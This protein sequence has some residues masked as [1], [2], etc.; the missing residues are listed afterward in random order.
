MPRRL[1]ALS[2]L[3]LAISSIA[4][5]QTLDSRD[6][7]GGVGLL[8]TPSARMAEEGEFAVTASRTSPYTR[9][10]FSLQPFPW[11]EGNFRY[12]NVT[13]VP[14][15]P[16]WLSGDQH[17]KD[18]SVDVKVRLWQ[19][20]RYLPEV[21][22]GVRDL[23]GTGLFASEYLV[24]S[25]RFGSVDASLGF[26]TG[27]M[28]S[29]GDFANPLGA[30]KERFKTRP[31]TSSGT[32]ADTGQVSWK[33]MFRGRVGVFGG[34]NWQTPW[35]RLALKL[36]YDGNDYSQEGRGLQIEQDSPI[37]L[38]AVFRLGESA[39][40]TVG[41][42]RGNEAVV[43]LTL[44]S[45]FAK[46][47]PAPKPLDPPPVALK[48]RATRA[49]DAAD[50]ADGIPYRDAAA[51]ASARREQ[52]VQ[53]HTAVD[54][55]DVSAQ[56]Y[57]NAGVDVERIGVRGNEL[58][59]AGVQGQY[60][61]PAQSLGRMAR[62][63][64][65][66]ASDDIEWFTLANRRTGL[67]VAETSIHRD[68]FA[69][70]VDGRIGL[71]ELMR[72]VELNP[73]SQQKR[74]PLHEVPVKPFSQSTGFGYSQIIGG[75]DGFILYQVSANYNANWWFNKNLWLA[76][77]ASY[78]L[79]NNYDKFRYDAP[80]NLPRVR[81][82]MR[83]FVTTSDFT[84]PNLQLTGTY[85]FSRD[86]YGMAYAGL[87]EYMYGGAGGELLYR[88][89]G[90]RWALGVDANW[91]KQRSYR[92]NASFRDY[93]V[94]TGHAT[95]YYTFGE[96]QRVA[97]A[98]SAGRYLAGDWGA[99]LSLTRV[100]DNGATMGAY[101]TKTDVSSEEFGEGSFDKGIYFSIP[102]DFLLPRSTQSRGNIMWQPL[103]RDGGARLIR[104]YNLHTLTGDR[105][106]DFFY[107]NRDRIGE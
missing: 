91:V 9:Y 20:S 67:D 27:Y 45:N 5:G 14:Y 7:W 58:I 73:P 52:V 90:E 103:V 86:V 54:W 10:N 17:Y 71:D 69:D 16:E 100:F 79:L 29:R 68:S 63:L 94:G 11:L 92:Q 15:G 41:W 6:D 88:P 38:G 87:L 33:D 31:D 77:T 32:W 64:D 102:F 24:A 28:G 96:Q 60:Y 84:I 46:L 44:R 53:A 81:T 57:Q 4:H 80:S 61:Q 37:N 39:Q 83:Q 62:I 75:P 12:T 8:Q 95:L 30:I 3:A 65:G 42:E 34:V 50:D 35:D 1:P 101:A 89:F 49:G 55:A 66:V 93:E 72:R 36:E 21:A 85:Q 2:L 56:L 74:E 23:G 26:A 59:V 43:G 107:G 48:P 22:A 76:G 106:T 40:F 47:R 98:L 99:T 18:K 82:D 51:L 104:R 70:Y 25:K 97:M 78:N 13:G 105:N 19:E